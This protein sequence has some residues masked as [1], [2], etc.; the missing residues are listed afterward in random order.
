MNREPFLMIPHYKWQG[1]R[2]SVMWFTSLNVCPDWN[3][4]LS[5]LGYWSTFKS[6]HFC[7]KYH[8]HLFKHHHVSSKYLLPIVFH[9]IGVGWKNVSCFPISPF[10]KV[11]N[12]RF[13]HKKHCNKFGEGDKFGDNSISNHLR[14]ILLS[15]VI[16]AP[17]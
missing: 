12:T 1:K 8:R 5:K 7:Q 10:Q 2:K 6:H 16:S 4:R 15:P 9:K 17:S 14:D 3:G 11:I 13:S